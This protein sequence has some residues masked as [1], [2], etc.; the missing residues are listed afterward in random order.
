[1]TPPVT[2]LVFSRKGQGVGFETGWRFSIGIKRQ[3]TRRTYPLCL[4]LVKAFLGICA[5]KLQP[6]WIATRG[7]R[8]RP[9]FQLSRAV[10]MATRR[11]Q[12]LEKRCMTCRKPGHPGPACRCIRVVSATTGSLLHKLHLGAGQFQQIPV[13]EK[14]RLGADRRAIKDRFF[15]AFDM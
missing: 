14:D 2:E 7:Q 13:F 3:Q 8:P 5:R 6:L 9:Y 1:M 12:C 10:Q 11:E 15:G 4:P